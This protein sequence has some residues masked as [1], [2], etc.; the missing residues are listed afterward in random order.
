MRLTTKELVA[1]AHR[2]ARSLPPESAK[3]V[4]ELATRLDITRAALCE[5]LCER[6]QLAAEARRGAA[7]VVSTLHH[8][9]A[10]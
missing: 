3:L 9:A 1:E 2:A 7:E 10:Q 4:T 8:G 5:S 6:D